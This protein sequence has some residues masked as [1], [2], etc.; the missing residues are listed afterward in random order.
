AEIA[1]QILWGIVARADR[2]D[3][4][5]EGLA[6][7]QGGF[8]D[9]GELFWRSAGTAGIALDQAAE[10][11]DFAQARTDIVVHVL[12]NASALPL[13][14]EFPFEPVELFQP[15]GAAAMDQPSSAQ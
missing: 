12:G 15:S 9:A 14:R 8:N 11:A 1:G 5:F 10:Q 3:D 4:F 6:R 2:P 13:D 7:L